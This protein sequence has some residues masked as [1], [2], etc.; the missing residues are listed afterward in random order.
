M[1]SYYVLTQF[2]ERRKKVNP[3]TVGNKACLEMLK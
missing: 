2:P 3:K 1:H